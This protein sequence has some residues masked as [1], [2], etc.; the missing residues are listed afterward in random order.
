MKRI[1]VIVTYVAHSLL[2]VFMVTMALYILT[3][4]LFF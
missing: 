2:F 3:H 4:A 1:T